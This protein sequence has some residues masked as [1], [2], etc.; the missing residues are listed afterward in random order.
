M[1][2]ILGFD[3]TGINA[4]VKFFYDTVRNDMDLTWIGLIEFKHFIAERP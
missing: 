2:T 4:H 3:G 1:K